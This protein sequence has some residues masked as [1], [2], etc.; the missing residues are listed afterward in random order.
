M[1]FDIQG[2]G[3]IAAVGSSDPF[4]LESFRLP[5]RKAYQGRCQVIIRAD[6]KPGKIVLKASAEGLQRAQVI[7][8]SSESFPPSTRG[9]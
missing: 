2:P 1:E 6:R 5:V 7:I 4:G 9:D 3:K 8:V